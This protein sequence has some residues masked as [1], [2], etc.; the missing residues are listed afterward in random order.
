M[1][2]AGDGAIA[3]DDALQACRTSSIGAMSRA[4]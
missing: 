2:V 1:Q 4:G 3:A